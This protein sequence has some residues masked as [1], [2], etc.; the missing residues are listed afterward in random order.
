MKAPKGILPTTG[1]KKE[2]GLRDTATLVFGLHG[3]G[4]TTLASNIPG[5][6][7]VDLEGGTNLIPGVKTMHP[8]TWEELVGVVQ[9]LGTEDH[10]FHAVVIDTADRAWSLCE[11]ATCRQLGIPYMGAAGRGK[12]WALAKSKWSSF[13]WDVIGLRGVDGRKLM[14]WFLA[15][16]KSQP[17]TEDRQGNSIDTGKLY[18]TVSLPNSAKNI[19]CS[20][21]DFVFHLD[22][23]EKTGKR[24]LRTQEV[25]T[26]R[27]RIYAKSRGVP[28]RSL[29]PVIHANFPAIRSEFDMTFNNEE[30]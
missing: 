13:V 30:S 4:K 18:V 16:E 28:N 9:A 10:N 26:P 25:D 20:A 29:P 12:D 23:D 3:K 6:L 1:T 5:S 2:I 14:P 8:T 7:I 21:V 17:I 24:M 22:I 19:L 15:H 27:A 11:K